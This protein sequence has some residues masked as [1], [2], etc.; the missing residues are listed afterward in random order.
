MQAPP[1][2]HS[3][4]RRKLRRG[5]AFTFLELHVSVAVLAI[6]L[7]GLL[8]LTVR[9]SRQ[10]ARM[11]AWCAADQT[12]RVIPQTE[13]WMRSLGAPATLTQS[14]DQQA[15]S[16]PVTDRDQ[17]QVELSSW[18]RPFGGLTAS[19]QVELTAQPDSN[20]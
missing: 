14:T 5:M 4:P 8:A 19:A 9:Q 1:P 7:L 18:A 10:V 15:W 6:G 2:W 17:Y 20:E 16:P 13:A 3:P 12:Y 11:E